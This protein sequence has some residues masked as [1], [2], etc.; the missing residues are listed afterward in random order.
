MI[1]RGSDGV[2]RLVRK[3]PSQSHS[4]IDV[5]NPQVQQGHETK[6]PSVSHGHWP[7]NDKRNWCQSEGADDGNEYNNEVTEE[8]VASEM[9]SAK[10]HRPSEDA[11]ADG[12]LLY[13]SYNPEVYIAPTDQVT[14]DQL[15]EEPLGPPT[16]DLSSLQ[17]TSY[18]DLAS[19]LLEQAQQSTL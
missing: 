8:A 6:R 3:R 10:R 16:L 2:N 9:H 19:K 14:P 18:E 15:S 17:V 13:A 5:C 12:Y 7:Q 1:V 4:C 11:S